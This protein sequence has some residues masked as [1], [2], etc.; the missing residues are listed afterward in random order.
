MTSFR[1]HNQ[2]TE[3]TSLFYAKQGA[4]CPF[5]MLTNFL[6]TIRINIEP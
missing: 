5:D 6:I 2:V 3:E 4:F 1:G